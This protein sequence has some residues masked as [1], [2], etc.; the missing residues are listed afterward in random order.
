SATWLLQ[1]PLDSCSADIPNQNRRILQS[2]CQAIAIGT[3]RQGGYVMVEYG[4]FPK[5]FAGSRLQKAN[6]R[7]PRCGETLAVRRKSAHAIR[8]GLFRNAPQ[9]FAIRQVEKHLVAA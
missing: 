4:A 3:E 7:P 8:V 9:L 6:T 2:R 5:E 1:I